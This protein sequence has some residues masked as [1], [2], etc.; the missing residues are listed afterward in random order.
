[1]GAQ[2]PQCGSSRSFTWPGPRLHPEPGQQVMDLQARRGR[3]SWRR[4]TRA[5]RRHEAPVTTSREASGHSSDTPTWRRVLPL[6]GRPEARRRAPRPEPTGPVS[7]VFSV[8]EMFLGMV[9]LAVIAA[10][11]LVP[12]ATGWVPL[13]VLTGS[14]RPGIPPGS[15]IVVQSVTVEEANQLQIGQ[16]ATY[17]P[18]ADSDLLVTHRIVRARAL[19]DGTARYE[20]KGDAN[21]VPDPQWVQPKQ[22]RGVLKYH[23]PFLGRVLT[24]LKPSTKEAW[25]TAA[26]LGL[27]VYALWEGAGAVIEWR[28]NKRKARK[29]AQDASQAGTEDRPGPRRY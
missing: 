7:F 8:L 17:Q 29:R 16:V 15:L 25:R 28:R 18:E 2:A 27:A 19:D 12:A 21:S 3:P 1:M 11:S 22:V 10:V 26:A 23:V 6:P 5:N 14:M 4:A 20:F 9:V 24:L 13:T